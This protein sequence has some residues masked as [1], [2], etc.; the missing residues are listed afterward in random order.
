M[1]SMEWS[2]G[3]ELWSGVLER[4]GVRF[5]SGKIR[6]ECSCGVC[7]LVCVLLIHHYYKIT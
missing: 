1:Y 6:M 3:A 4:S 7:V 5:W 2:L